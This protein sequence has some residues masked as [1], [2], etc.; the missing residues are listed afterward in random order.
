MLIQSH[1]GYIQLLPA[2]PDNWS[3][4]SFTGLRTR[5]GFEIDAKWKNGQLTLA[6]IKADVAESFKLMVLDYVTIVSVNKKK[7]DIESGFISI[8]LNRGEKIKIEFN[9]NTIL[10]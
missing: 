5:G 3:E 8:N 2:L 10:D 1:N 9:P 4:G 7:M 6:I